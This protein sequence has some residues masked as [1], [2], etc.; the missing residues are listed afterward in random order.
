MHFDPETLASASA[1]PRVAIEELRIEGVPAFHDGRWFLPP[2]SSFAAT[3]LSPG[4]AVLPPGSGRLLEFR[5]TAPVFAAPEKTRFRYRLLGHEEDWQYADTRRFALYTNLRPGSYRFEV[6]ACSVRGQWAEIPAHLAFRLRPFI[7]QTTWFWGLTGALGLGLAASIHQWRLN[8]VRRLQ[9]LQQQHALDAER[10][11][12]ATDLH[13]DLGARLSHLVLLTEMLHSQT[14]NSPQAARWRREL[15][16]EAREAA[17]SVNETVWATNP[18]RDRIDHLISFLVQYTEHFLAPTGL[19]C[20]FDLPANVP[21]LPVASAVRHGIFLIL[22][23][24]LHNIVSLARARTVRLQL[25]MQCDGVEL[26]IQDDGRGL[27]PGLDYTRGNGLNNM[28]QRAQSLGGALRY[29]PVPGGGTCVVL[30]MSHAALSACA[31]S[32]RP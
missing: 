2:V 9:T 11:R 16:D 15:V 21:T 26:R 13:D 25:I 7:Y 5:Y 3:N 19:D 31:R 24:A 12:I 22:K 30:C 27:E 18:E 4:T 28:R 20:R 17:Q 8:N 14:Q 29:E 32:D 6:T 23:E 10:A 1:A